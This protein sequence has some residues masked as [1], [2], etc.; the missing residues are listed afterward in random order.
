MVDLA[1]KNLLHDRLRFVITL[2]GVA[3][4]VA[5]VMVQVGLFL[6]LLSFSTVTIDRL[7]ADIWVTNQNARN[8]DFAIRFPETYVDRVRAIPG[9]NRADNM[10]VVF[11]D[12]RL[13]T[14][15][16]EGG[17][18]Y[19]L[20]DFRAW[21]FPWDIEEGNVEDL[22]R[23]PTIF[24]D[25]SADHR[26]GVRMNVGD[27]LEVQGQRMQISGRTRGARSFTTTPLV[28][29][30]YRRVQ[31]LMPHYRGLASYIVVK[32]QPGADAEEVKRQI[33]ERLPRNMVMGAK[34]WA[35]RT[36]SYWIRSTGLGFNMFI[37]V[38]L[39][40]VVAVIIVAQTLYTSTMEHLRE[41]GMVKAIGG[42]NL[43]IYAILGRQAIFAA[44]CGYGVGLIPSFITRYFI[45][46]T[47]L[48]VVM[49]PSLLIVVFLG[50]MVLC[51][52]AAAVSFRK[53]ATIDP[54][55]VFRS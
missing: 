1:L 48:V 55:L 53:I 17:I 26:F 10:F 45:Q 19:A 43:D 30:D 28:F 47:G 51:L 5:L 7:P 35:D 32:L 39:G 49:S 44:V 36:K 3:F 18:I 33:Q 4:S 16:Q 27:Y 13:P 21:D 6:G 42:S 8:V 15:G 12:I 41:F 24:I 31:E 54:A 38:F 2:S 29:M 23:G 40:G 11:T 34:D 9:V 46:R 22:R 25:G 37:T 20:D 52:L 50:T 14:G